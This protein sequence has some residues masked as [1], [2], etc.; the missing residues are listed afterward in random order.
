MSSASV[1]PN[2][3][4]PEVT[5]AFTTLINMCRSNPTET[6]IRQVASPLF[7]TID[8]WDM[9]EA[10]GARAA[11]LAQCISTGN[12][13]QAITIM[14][15]IYRASISRGES[16]SLPPSPPTSSPT[17]PTTTT[18]SVTTSTPQAMAVTSTISSLSI[19]RRRDQ[20]SQ[21]ATTSST[22]PTTTS[23][24][25]KRLR[26]TP[27]SEATSEVPQGIVRR[28][29]NQ[30]A[31]SMTTDIRIPAV[32]T[33]A[34]ALTIPS[35]MPVL[36]T[37]VAVA[38][39]IACRRL[40]QR[41]VLPSDL[42]EIYETGLPLLEKR[43]RGDTLSEQEKTTL[44]NLL[45]H[46]RNNRVLNNYLKSL[47]NREKTKAIKFLIMYSY[48]T[49]AICTTYTNAQSR[50]GNL[51]TR[52]EVATI[53]TERQKIRRKLRD[54]TAS[55]AL[56]PPINA[57]DESISTT[58]MRTNTREQMSRII[59]QLQLQIRQARTSGNTE[60]AQKLQTMRTSLQRLV[61]IIA[62]VPS[63]N[64]ANWRR[65]YNQ[66]YFSFTSALI[67]YSTSC[68]EEADQAFVDDMRT[69]IMSNLNTTF[70]MRNWIIWTI[71]KLETLISQEGQSMDQGKR[72]RV[73]AI[74][75]ELKKFHIDLFEDLTSVNVNRSVNLLTRWHRNFDSARTSLLSAVQALQPN[76][77]PANVSSSFSQIIGEL[78]LFSSR[79][80][81]AESSLGTCHENIERD[82]T[83]LNNARQNFA[84][85]LNELEA[86]RSLFNT[87]R[88]F[89]KDLPPTVSDD[90]PSLT[91]L[92]TLCTTAVDT[93]AAYAALMRDA[94]DF[95]A[96]D[97]LIWDE[98]LMPS[99]E[100]WSNASIF[101]AYDIA[102]M[103][104]CVLQG[105]YIQLQTYFGQFTHPTMLNIRENELYNVHA[106]GG[107]TSAQS[108]SAIDN[109][110]LQLSHVGQS[111]IYEPDFS[112]LI[113]SQGMT[114]LRDLFQ[115]R[116]N[117][118]NDTE[119]NN[120][121]QNEVYE[122]Y[123]MAVNRVL[124]T[125]QSQINNITFDHTAAITSFIRRYCPNGSPRTETELLQVFNAPGEM[126]CSQFASTLM[127]R[128]LAEVNRDL[129]EEYTEVIRQRQGPT[130]TL[131][132]SI[133]HSVI[134]PDMP[135]DTVLPNRLQQLITQHMHFRRR[136]A[137]MF[138]VL[139]NSH[140]TA[141]QPSSQPVTS[142]STPL[143]S[144]P[145][146]PTT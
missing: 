3:I 129:Q 81:N 146:P 6:R 86:M 141:P 32:L 135:F 139:V 43:L 72:Q 41:P 30:L 140:P 27:S 134:P 56:C 132:S 105:N 93:F 24:T 75:R 20:P 108:T 131:P 57:T 70:G 95:R 71:S 79:I 2:T 143:P 13:A 99:R 60:K 122:R 39:V 124:R 9:G 117:N 100:M 55:I 138:A 106:V 36:G 5:T 15:E 8:M 101:N 40:G 67:A 44:E 64:Y 96:G 109:A 19:K 59:D 77:I 16:V 119:Y 111:Q 90:I 116:R 130:P 53:Q 1:A 114:M 21:V 48:K 46:S 61:N 76:D 145:S 63:S 65:E 107:D 88:E 121:I 73:G 50:M 29:L 42:R 97:I 87:Y 14:S 85:S 137:S 136:D 18:T 45:V 115:D 104:R 51:L 49:G 89:Y 68:T 35:I 11:D 52:P 4:N 113:T 98:T 31:N 12:D 34:V 123:Q 38:S 83:T 102:R 28:T 118:R 47:P 82:M 62:N 10:V 37:G 25:I 142:S 120:F 26:H 80:T 74:L 66:V 92:R 128:T 133:F 23:Q 144:P 54:I 126:F 22:T 84:I 17:P 78:E 91:E 69:G 7:A 33:T 103:A 125:E 94:S 110:L 112:Q 127:M 58:T